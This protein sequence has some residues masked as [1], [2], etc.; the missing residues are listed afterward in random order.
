MSDSKELSPEVFERLL[1]RERRSRKEAERLLDQKSVELYD[2]N[3]R[4]RALADDLEQ[5]VQL[6]TTELEAERNRAVDAAGALRE[7]ERRFSDVASIVGEY[8]WE[9]DANYCFTTVTSHVASVLGYSEAELIGRSILDYMPAEDASQMLMAFQEASSVGQVFTKLAHRSH[10]KSGDVVWQHSSG[11]PSFDSAGVLIGFRGAS[12]DVS[13]QERSKQQMQ[14]LVIAL[15]HASEGIVMTDPHG[16]ILFANDAFALMFG[17]E[18]TES[19]I[20]MRWQDFYRGDEALRFEIAITSQLTASEGYSSEGV[21]RRRDGSEFPGHFSINRLPSRELLWIC[22]DESE[23][24]STLMSLQTQNSL[25]SALL[26]NIRV[27][28]LF[29]DSSGAQSVLYNNTIVEMFGLDRAAFTDVTVVDP[30]FEQLGARC[31]DDDSRAAVGLLEGIEGTRENIEI[32]LDE[33]TYLVADRIPVF[34]GR[35]YRGALWAIRDVSDAKRQELAMHEAR[36]RAE[37]GDHAK[38]TFLANMSHEIRTPLN[39]ICGMARILMSASLNHDAFEQVRG[40]QISADSLLHVLNDILDFSKVEAGQLDIEI[41]DFEVAH[42]LDSAFTVLQSKAAEQKLR[43]DFIY[44][45][46]SLPVLK[47]D[48]SRLNEVLL[49]L[50]GNAMKFTTEGGVTLSCEVRAQAAESV[51]LLLS[52][53][54]TGIGMSAEDVD[55]VFEPFT[56]ADSSISR[57]FGG[58]GL[59]L[60]IS[61]DLVKL[62]GGEMGVESAVGEGSVFSFELPFA[63][64]DPS[65]AIEST[66]E[67]PAMTVFVLTDSSVMYRMMDSMLAYARAEVIRVRSA[68]EVQSHLDEHCY[69]DAVMLIDRTS[70]EGYFP[71]EDIDVLFPLPNRLHRILISEKVLAGSAGEAE[72]MEYPFSRYQLLR[73]IHASLG[74]ELPN[75]IFQIYDSTSF[76]SVDLHGLRVL[77]AEDNTINQKVIRMMIERFG[78]VADVAANGLEVLELVERFEYDLVLMDIR[79]P[80][81]DGVEAC[82]RLRSMGLTLPVYALTADAMKGDRER[83][84]QAGMNGYLSKPMVEADIVNVLLDNCS[85]NTDG[86]ASGV[87]ALDNSERSP[88][89]EFFDKAPNEEVLD[90]EGFYQLLGGETEIAHQLLDQFVYYGREYAE[91]GV[92]ALH[93]NDLETARS[94]FHKLAGSAATIC[95]HQVRAYFLSYERILMGDAPDAATCLERTAVGM[96]AFERLVVEIQKIVEEK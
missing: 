52:V 63:V 8:L 53:S 30:I 25:L 62:M 92:Q 23:R 72:V 7:S 66:V 1:A 29:E 93:D 47:G 11:A 60:A 43:F 12:L 61:R 78:G 67:S 69:G 38:S 44:P 18:D 95:A 40:I 22:R 89:D 91:E 9:I 84:M 16:A 24:L 14:Q 64:S 32:S 57:R 10:S 41:V 46:A 49:N 21:G 77:V 68:S 81:M 73:V 54:D 82:L 6:R 42:V 26:E 58:S 5:R 86:V 13:E 76:D 65:S 50:L 19:L 70:Q 35:T 59:G 87:D 36:L 17:H 56:Q 48:P 90:L 55:N 28:V 83:F 31:H 2:A 51:T 3:Q 96:V 4:L 45:D 15:Q 85:F 34:V 33:D 79:M 27:G 37:A 88:A 39:G 75:G 20:G 80:E 71:E 74:R 94:R